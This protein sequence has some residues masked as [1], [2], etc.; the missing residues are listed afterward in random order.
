VVP[1]ELPLVTSEEAAE[2]PRPPEDPVESRSAPADLAVYSAADASV[3]QPALVRPRLP[4]RPGGGARE[5]NLP[6][7]ELVVS[8][9]GEVE[10]VKLVTE[11]ADVKSAMMLSAIKT[12]RFDPAT[13]D[14]IPVRYRLRLRLTNQ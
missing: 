2:L 11:P 5:A 9:S 13:R 7:V 14:G 8:P 4:T 6:Q 12:W 1:E 3:A 10:V